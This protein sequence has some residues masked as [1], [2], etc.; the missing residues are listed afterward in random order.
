VKPSSSPDRRQPVDPLPEL[1]VRPRLVT[2]DDGRPLGKD[3]GRAVEE[4]H[5]REGHV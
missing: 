2:I 1:G 5:R 3:T 4:R